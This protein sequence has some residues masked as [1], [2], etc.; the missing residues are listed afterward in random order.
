MNNWT[1]Y[2]EKQNSLLPIIRTKLTKSMNVNQYM[3]TKKRQLL[4][5]VSNDYLGLSNHI[6]V[7]NALINASKMYGI[8][9]G[10]SPFLGGQSEEH[11]QL[12]EELAAWIGCEKCLLFSSGYQL[13]IGIF[14][15]LVDN[16]THIWLDKH[17]HASHIDGILLS[18]AKF[19]TFNAFNIDEIILKIKQNL[20]H[21]H[22]IISE[23]VFSMDGSC[24][25]WDKLIQLKLEHPEQV[26][27]IIDDAHGIGVCGKNGYGTLEQLG[28]NWLHVDLIIGTFGKGFG[29]HGGFI[30]GATHIIDYLEQRI[31]SHIFSTNLPPAIVAATRASLRIICSQQGA[32][33]R[34]KLNAN[35]NYFHELCPIN[36]RD[37]MLNFATNSNNSPIQL[38]IYNDPQKVFFMYEYLFKHDI[39]VGKIFYPTVA[40]DKPRIRISL[41]ATHEKSDINK[42]IATL[43]NAESAYTLCL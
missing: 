41:S 38:L 40:K 21:R 13:N 11:R 9:S 15:P 25:Y 16:N 22:I 26:L 12:T 19:T 39:L 32:D 20:I 36:S 14:S 17:C 28:L 1:K 18:K 4:N 5:F 42:L 6:E 29:T 35:I 3:I 7:V 2:I 23:G 37:L 10:G 33:L 27:L 31:R 24:F 43:I 34:N 30:C 8:G